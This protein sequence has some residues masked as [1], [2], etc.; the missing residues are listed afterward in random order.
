MVGDSILA[1]I[2]TKMGGRG[3]SKECLFHSEVL[4][5]HSVE[6]GEGG[7]GGVTVFASRTPLTASEP[8]CLCEA[9]SCEKPWVY[10][11]FKAFKSMQLQALQGD[12]SK[13]YERKLF[14]L[15]IFNNKKE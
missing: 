13:Q 7:G 9:Y 10:L 8:V 2:T 3:V 1:C 12:R 14:N 5:P 11:I 4:C 6:W 15:Q